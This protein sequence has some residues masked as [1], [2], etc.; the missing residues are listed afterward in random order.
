MTLA[1]GKRHVHFSPQ[2]ES[3]D[4]SHHHGHQSDLDDPFTGP[5]GSSNIFSHTQPQVCLFYFI[6]FIFILHFYFW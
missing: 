4:L 1:Q 2:A 5:G 3:A 6:Y